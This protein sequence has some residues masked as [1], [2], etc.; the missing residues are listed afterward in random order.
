V[1]D[2]CDA[3]LRVALHG[4]RVPRG[5]NGAAPVGAGRYYVAAD[6]A[7]TYGQ[8]GQLAARAAGWAVATL[9]TPRPVFY[10]AGAIGEVMGRL[11]GRPALV[12]FDKVRETMARGWV[13][14]DEKLRAS[15]GY[16]PQATL[17]ERF[18]E[19][20]AWYREHSWL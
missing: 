7:V 9:P 2:L 8:L 1:T 16:A 5:A 11:R 3:L 14:S 18:A 15:L 20:V 19:T 4:E 12:N 6:R 13:C 17:E 10:L